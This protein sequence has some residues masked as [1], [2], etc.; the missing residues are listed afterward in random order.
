MFGV[1][2]VL[3]E[4]NEEHLEYIKN[5]EESIIERIVNKYTEHYFATMFEGVGHETSLILLLSLTEPDTLRQ[6]KFTD[7]EIRLVKNLAPEKVLTQRLPK[8]YVAVSLIE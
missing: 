7:H 2:K 3:L 8:E 6:S 5:E 1:Q 4:Q